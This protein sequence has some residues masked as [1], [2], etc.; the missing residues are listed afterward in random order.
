LGTSC[1]VQWLLQASAS[2]FVRLW[3]SLSGDS[4]IRLLSACT[5]WHSQKYLGLVTV[6][7]TDP[8]WGILWVPFSSVS[9]PHF[10][11]TFPPVR[12]LFPPLSWKEANTLVVRIE[13]L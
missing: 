4:Y 2:V 11:S 12:I 6:Y 5:S 8:M 9:A 1:S 10:V 7:G 3:Q 13:L